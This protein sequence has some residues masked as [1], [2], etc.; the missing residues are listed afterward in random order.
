MSLNPA[1][2]II[3]P[4]SQGGENFRRCLS[5]LAELSPAPLETI[6]V[7]NEDQGNSLELAAQSKA[8]ILTIPSAVGPGKAR[9]VGAGVASGDILFFIDADV[10]VSQD[11]VSR[12]ASLFRDEKDLTAIFGSYDD[13]PLDKSFLSQYKNL[14]HH[15]IHQSSH[16]EASTFWGGC[17]AV[18]REAF[19][20]AGG[21]SEKYLRPSIEDIE[22]GRC[23]KR[24]GHRI[25]LVKSLQVKHLKRWDIVSLIQSDFFDRAIPWT[26][27]ILREKSFPNDLNLK[28][29]S[30]L[31]ILLVYL[32]LALSLG[33]FIF[34]PVSFPFIALPMIALFILNLPL[35]N[36]FQKKR[37]LGFA[38]KAVF[39]HWFYY[40]YSGL[41]FLAESIRY[42]FQRACK[43]PLPL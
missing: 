17:G 23:L 35:Y 27:L 1:V 31:S 32:I 37:G 20:S 14:F 29:S 28:I 12:V 41:A 15:Y 42:L 18:R 4:V 19:F 8:R 33:L 9:N 26:E 25:R 21:F 30:R 6:I 13:S 24:A 7:V 34:E 10:M 5:S 39:W 11:A 38:L 16:E 40:F 43:N 2:S 22:L 36:F 3:I